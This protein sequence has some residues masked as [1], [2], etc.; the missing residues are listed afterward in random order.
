MLV[1][2]I[3][4]FELKGF[5]PPWLYMYSCNCLFIWQNKN[6]QGKSSRGLLF[7]AKILHEAVYLRAWYGME[8]KTI[9]PYSIL[10]IFFHSSSI[11]Y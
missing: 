10:E 8:W 11:P 5:G 2:L 4:E 7:T 6:L 1:I 9:F 3:I